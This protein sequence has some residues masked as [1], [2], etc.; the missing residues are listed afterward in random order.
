MAATDVLIVAE[1]RDG[2]LRPLSLELV[3]AA[4]QIAGDGKI[5]RA[6]V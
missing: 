4:R 1:T 2:K 6:H 5:G 3:T